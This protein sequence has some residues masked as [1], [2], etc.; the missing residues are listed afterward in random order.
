MSDTTFSSGTVIA[1][2]WLN[3]VNTL[4]YNPGD[5]GD[6]FQATKT[7]D[8]LQEVGLVIR[9][10]VTATDPRFGGISG[11]SWHTAI[12]AAASYAG[13]N[14]LGLRLLPQSGGYPITD[15]VTIPT[16]VLAFDMRGTYLTYSGTRDRPIMV[17]GQTGTMTRYAVYLGLNVQGT[18]VDW[19]NTSYIAI[20]SYNLN[21]CK[22]DIMQAVGAYVGFDAA[23]DSSNGWAYNDVRV[24]WL[25]DCARSMRLTSTGANCFINE[26]N[27]YAGRYGNSSSAT[28]LGTGYGVEVTSTDGLYV[29]HNNNRW[30]GPT[31]ELIGASGVTRIPFFFNGAGTYCKVI[32]ARHESSGGV[33][34]LCDGLSRSGAAMHNEFDVT[35]VAGSFTTDGITQQNGA[36]G[37]VY[38]SFTP[39]NK[40]NAGWV[41]SDVTSCVKPN[42]ANTSWLTAVWSYYTNATPT[43]RKTT[44]TNVEVAGRLTRPYL[45][46]GSS[47]SVIG[48]ELRTDQCRQWM[49]RCKCDG[50]ANYG[51]LVVRAFDVTG[52]QITTGTAVT[53]VQYNGT[54]AAVAATAS[55]G[56]A[57][58]SSSD[59]V[60]KACVLL[61][62]SSVYTVHIGVSGG[63]QPAH[64]QG[65]ELYPL[66]MTPQGTSV[67]CSVGEDTNGYATADPDTFDAF[68][69]LRRGEMVG[70]A[71]A[72]VGSP[73]GWICT[74]SG[75]NAKAWAIT[76]AYVV[77]QR[78][79]NGANVY[80]CTTAGTS[81]GAGG[82]AGTGTNIADGTVVWDFLETRIV[83]SAMANL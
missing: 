38:K 30:W 16:T 10:W 60:G 47:A 17:L 61:F 22:V 50:T 1:S 14:G 57:Y 4:T 23:C 13:A 19:S 37:N 35:Y 48:V 34:A 66:E 79:Y 5:A 83:S 45:R 25:Q 40:L 44:D 53:S 80:V 78:R 71:S 74:T 56:N 29:S 24:G 69:S 41:S 72:A 2:S 51:R 42:A 7:P 20:K 11:G 26:N 46:I 27:F 67:F 28:G 82:P 75:S 76:T 77:G 68:G 32:A 73:V 9:K 65:L 63:S 59:G 15:T 62:D 31:F 55:F 52:T 39:A 18:T 8:Q 58:Q 49:V 64:L 70:H 12:N 54:T 33:F 43:I 21:R 6:Y 36:I 3:D 81:A